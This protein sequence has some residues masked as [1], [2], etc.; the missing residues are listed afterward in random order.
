MMRLA[1]GICDAV[2]EPVAG[3]AEGLAIAKAD[4][5]AVVITADEAAVVKTAEDAA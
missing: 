3:V 5:R 2:A 4:D 1:M